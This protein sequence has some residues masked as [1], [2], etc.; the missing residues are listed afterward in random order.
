MVQGS[1]WKHPADQPVPLLSR[2]VTAHST[3]CVL[4]LACPKGA[5]AVAVGAISRGGGADAKSVNPRVRAGFGT[6]AVPCTCVGWSIA[7]CRG[8][9]SADPS[10]RRAHRACRPGRRVDWAAVGGADSCRDPSQVTE[11]GYRRARRRLRSLPSGRAATW[12]TTVRVG[13]GRAGRHS[14]ISLGQAAEGC[15]NCQPVDG[16]VGGAGR[17]LC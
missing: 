16:V 12:R 8:S 14:K 9:C 3:D 17:V 11:A 10:A 1:G 5:T 2:I 7:V 6:P 4:D 15:V 13:S